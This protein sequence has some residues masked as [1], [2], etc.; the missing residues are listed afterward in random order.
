M[1]LPFYDQFLIPPA[2]LFARKGDIPSRASN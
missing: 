1:Q 2:D